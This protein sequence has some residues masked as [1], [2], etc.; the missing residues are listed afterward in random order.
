[1][2]GQRPEYRF[3]VKGEGQEKWTEIGAAWKLASGNFS[4]RLDPENSGGIVKCLMVKANFKEPGK[5]A[6][7]KAQPAEQKPAA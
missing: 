7:K 5:P 6:T 1:M 4:V 2:P 3:V